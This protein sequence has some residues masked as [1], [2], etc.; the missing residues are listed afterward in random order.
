MNHLYRIIT[1]TGKIIELGLMNEVVAVDCY[2]RY[3]AAHHQEEKNNSRLEVFIEHD[4]NH[5][6]APSRWGI[7]V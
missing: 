5:I 6:G 4:N 1:G 7:I 3:C 2:Q